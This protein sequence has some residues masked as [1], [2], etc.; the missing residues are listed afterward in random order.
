MPKSNIV[1]M[2]AQ[3]RIFPGPQEPPQFDDQG[4]HFLLIG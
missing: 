1:T 4:H 3:A 2:I